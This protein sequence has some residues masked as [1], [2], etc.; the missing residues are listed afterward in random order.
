MEIKGKT[1][2][3]STTW[4]LKKAK[5]LKGLKR[6]D[7]YNITPKSSQY[8]H[9]TILYMKKT[10]F[11]IIIIIF[12]I[13]YIYA[14]MRSSLFDLY[15]K[16]DVSSSGNNGVLQRGHVMFQYA[17]HFSKHSLWKTWPQERLFTS[18]SSSN[19][20]RHTEHSCSVCVQ[21]QTLLNWTL[22]VRL[23]NSSMQ[24]SE[25]QKSNSN[26]SEWVWE[27]SGEGDDGAGD[28]EDDDDDDDERL[29]PTMWRIVLTMPLTK[30]MEK[31]VFT[32]STHNTP[33]DGAGRLERPMLMINA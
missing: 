17:N 4:R 15:Q 13:I 27:I 6:S 24:Y 32:K 31:A 11:L 3:L 1:K 25:E 18:D 28:D 26:E 8:V 23:L 22:G 2:C 14:C 12:I 21:L 20:V 29:I 5:G 33:S 7:A 9:T 30:D 16:Q 19:W 10:S